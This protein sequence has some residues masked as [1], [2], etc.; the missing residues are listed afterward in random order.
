MRSPNRAAVWVPYG[1]PQTW[2]GVALRTGLSFAEAHGLLSAQAAGELSAEHPGAHVLGIDEASVSGWAL[3]HVATRKVQSSGV[4]KGDDAKADLLHRLADRIDMR[5]LLVCLEDHRFIPQQAD[6]SARTH[7]E[8]ETRHTQKL[9]ALGRA[10]GAWQMGL[11]ML[12]HPA[13]QRLM[14]QPRVWRAVLGTRVNLSR[15]AWKAQAIRWA[16]AVM[17]EPVTQADRAEAIGIAM[18]GAWDGLYQ[19]ASLT[20]LRARGALPNGNA[21]AVRRGKTS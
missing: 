10:D 4:V 18:W 11:S 20:R 8:R 15:E 19:W 1:H 7:R 9:L 21:R 6:H 5:S 12:R 13:A 2:P 14:V 16:S 3:V 17:Q